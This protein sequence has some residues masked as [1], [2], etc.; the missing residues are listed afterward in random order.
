MKLSPSEILDRYA[1]VYLKYTRISPDKFSKEFCALD[2]E[3]EQLKLQFPQFNWESWN[4][5]FLNIHKFIW[6]LEAGTKSCKETLPEPN[7]LLD[8]KN[9]EV[10][11]KAGIINFLIK[12]FNKLRVEFKNIV[13]ELCKEGFI[14]IKKNHLSE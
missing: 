4:T 1:I 2:K 7:Y 12:D 11:K 9:D 5:Y 10:L 8:K 13:S 6:R 3:I 14:D